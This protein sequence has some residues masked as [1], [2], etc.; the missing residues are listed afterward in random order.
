MP[1]TPAARSTSPGRYHRVSK[2]KSG[3]ATYTPAALA[4]F[5]AQKIVHA[6]DLGKATPRL[7]VLDPAVGDGA[8]LLSLLAHLPPGS[9]AAISVHGFDTDRAA[10]ATARRRLQA[11]FPHVALHLA[12]GDFL[13][14][15]PPAHK[16]SGDELF[17]LVIANPPYVRT[18]ILGTRQAQEL[19]AA[20]GLKGRVDLYFA[21]LMGI[22]QVL[23]PGG[24]AGVI[25]SN[26]FMTTRAGAAVRAALRERF[27]L[28][29]VWDLGDTKLFDAAVLPAVLLAEGLR[30]EA[31]AASAP[32]TFTSIYE[33]DAPAEHSATDPLAALELE[34]AV[35]V[36]D[37]RRFLVRQGLLDCGGEGD[38]GA[39]WCGASAKSDAWL[40]TVAAHTWGQFRD[41][42]RARVGVKSCADPVFIRCDWCELPARSRPELLRPIITHHIA[43]RFRAD[44]A[45]AQRQILYPHECV[46]GE[47]R[48]I[49][50]KNYPRSSRYL[51]AHRSQLESRTY[52]LAA[53]RRWY[54]L[55]VPQDPAAFSALKLVFRDIA[56]EP[57]FWI[58]Q[59]GHI[60]NGDCYWMIAE[61]PHTDDLLWLAAAV[62]NSTFCTA[63]YDQRFNNRLYAGRRRF[64]AQYVEEFPLPDPEK[65]P[66]REL[67]ALAKQIYRDIDQPDAQ[68]HL[69]L[70]ERLNAKVW[71]AFGLART[72]C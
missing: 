51:E 47:R 41:L 10:L 57:T 61:K 27:R 2:K 33:T 34:G 70:A 21:F 59:Q 7:R 28:R 15:G 22:A 45:Q 5:V 69:Q 32:A 1:S 17:D 29:Q 4:D 65:P 18:Q 49:D 19:A 11:A 67:I 39:V 66:G 50:L 58:D 52:L 16:R 24:V 20:F 72:S 40:R 63:F 68:R 64:I 42:G 3:G 14:A 9:F 26:R 56:R 35:A 31:P 37:G 55:W 62:A 54:E 12:A 23:R 44:E 71:A 25:V 6:A 48:P 53:G 30:P 46:Q 43:R 36:A 8:L 13:D 60:V 38:P